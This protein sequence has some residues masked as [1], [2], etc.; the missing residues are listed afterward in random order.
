MTGQVWRGPGNHRE[1]IRQMPEVCF[2]TSG[3]GPYFDGGASSVLSLM[4]E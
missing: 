4:I 1:D 2:H 3:N